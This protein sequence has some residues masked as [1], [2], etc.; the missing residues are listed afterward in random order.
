MATFA[1]VLQYL[2]PNGGYLTSGEEYSG[3]TF[4]ECDPITEKEFLDGFAKV[5]KAKKAA[6]IKRNADREALLT[7]LGITADEAALLLS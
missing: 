3:I 7:K 4:L 5:D 6:E 1:E 2:I